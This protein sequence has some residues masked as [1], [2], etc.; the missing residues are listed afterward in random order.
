MVYPC[1]EV[2]DVVSSIHVDREQMSAVWNWATVS[3]LRTTP[4]KQFGIGFGVGWCVYECVCVHVYT[5]YFND[6]PVVMQVVRV[7]FQ[8]SQQNSCIPSW[9]WFHSLTG[10]HIIV[11]SNVPYS[12]STCTLYMDI[13]IHI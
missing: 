10:V 6:I 4:I 9:V 1:P 2:D 13:Y 8:K 5:Y 12:I 11:Y 3:A 7:S